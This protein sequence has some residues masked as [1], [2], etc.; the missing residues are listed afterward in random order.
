MYNGLLGLHSLLR[1]AMVIFLII[2]IVRVNVEADEHFDEVDKKWSLRLLIVTH[3]NLLVGLYQYFMGAF[4]I[5]L[6]T[7]RTEGV[8]FAEVMKDPVRRYWVVEHI[9]GMIIAVILITIAHSF[10][11][12]M[13]IEPLKKHRRMSWILIVALLIIVANAPW[14]FRIEGIA[15]PWFRGMY[16]I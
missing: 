10:S 7:S 15:R 2:N 14:P 5:S 13:V 12:N 3:I 9:S 4:G 16:E 11:K 1:W 6:L 8:S